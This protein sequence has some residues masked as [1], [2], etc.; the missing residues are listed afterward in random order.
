[1]TNEREKRFTKPCGNFNCWTSS[2]LKLGCCPERTPMARCPF[3]DPEYELE[4]HMPCP[5]C[6]MFGGGPT[7]DEDKCVGD[8]VDTGDET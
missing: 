3:I 5:V 6:G 7:D 4:D 8:A 1:M 2:P